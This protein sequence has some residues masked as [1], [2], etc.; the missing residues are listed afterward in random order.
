MQG[1]G[2]TKER[3]HAR[4]HTATASRCGLGFLTTWR[5]GSWENVQQGAPGGNNVSFHDFTWEV[6]G[7]PLLCVKSVQVRRDGNESAPLVWRAAEN[8]AAV[9]SGKD[10]CSSCRRGRRGSEEERLR[11]PRATLHRTPGPRHLWESPLEGCVHS[12]AEGWGVGSVT[13]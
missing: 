9:T 13:R 8:V 6:T 2:K 3:A 10:S 7:H 1:Q 5:P 4:T 12:L 11:L